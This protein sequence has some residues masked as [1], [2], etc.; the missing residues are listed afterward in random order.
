MKYYKYESKNKSLL[1]IEQLCLCRVPSWNASGLDIGKWDGEVFVHQD[2]TAYDEFDT[3]V[4][5]FAPIDE[6]G[7]PEDIE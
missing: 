1:M 2:D 5:E 4:E 6:D 7:N 3:C